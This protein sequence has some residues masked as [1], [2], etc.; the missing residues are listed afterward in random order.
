M[1]NL[2]ARLESGLL[3]YL[4][5]SGAKGFVVGV[6]GGLD[7]AVSATLCATVAPTHALI[8]PTSVSNFENVKDAVKLT[9]KLNLPC[10]TLD[11]SEILDAFGA[12]CGEG[13]L[14]SKGNLMARI[15][16]CVLYDYS[17]KHGLLVCGTS[18]K[19]ERMLG[20]GTVWGDM[21]CAVN[22]LGQIYKSDLF[23]FAEFLGVDAAIVAKKPSADLFAGQSD[24]GDLGY[25]YATLDAVLKAL[26]SGED[27]SKFDKTLVDFVKSR[28]KS[29]EFKRRGVE[30]LA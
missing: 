4:K 12:T 9:Q 25:T 22:P 18:N 10:K 13:S 23:A 28:V 29:S 15:R 8:M 14:A 1:Q 5:K 11:I 16:M 6:S 20:Y 17:F 26:E 3:T 27:L 24:E 7:S 19:S 21:A 30:I 2:K